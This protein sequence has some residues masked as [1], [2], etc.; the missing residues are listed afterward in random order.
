MSRFRRQL[1]SWHGFSTRAACRYTGGCMGWKPMPRKGFT[2]LEL[3]L[4]MTCACMLAVTLY[5]SL[6]I[7]IKSRD[8]AEAAV[9]PARQAQVA[10]E[11]IGRDLESA[12]PP[13]SST[14]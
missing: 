6:R 11:L 13:P 5:A 14:S 1:Q 7:G 10:L 8:H 12:L 2:L 3:I 4:A 9:E